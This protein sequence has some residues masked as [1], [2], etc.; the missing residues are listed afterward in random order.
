MNTIQSIILGVIQG[1]TEWLPI[2]SEG[3]TIMFA[4]GLLGITAS[5]ALSY[6]IFLH[7]GTMIA[8]LIVFRHTWFEILTLRDIGLLRILFVTSICTG[9]TAV[10][11]YFLLRQTFE[12]GIAV[13]VIIGVLLIITGIMLRAKRSGF[14]DI[15][16]M[17][18]R[19]MALLG[20]IQGF[21][22][23][24]GISRSAV[25]ISTLLMRGFSSD[26]ALTVSFLVSVPPVIG[27]IILDWGTT[28]ISYETGFFMAVTAAIVGYFA[29]EILLKVARSVQFSLFCIIIGILAIL[30]GIL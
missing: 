6:A 18:I 23:L 13:T 11:L 20:C 5:D 19:D 2:S 4:T 30:A 15:S 12:S 16:A 22:V 25:T 8:V 17:K 24:P 27:V 29:M 7:L 9:I 28:P 1:I 21:S 10:P 14:K 26:V 3:Q